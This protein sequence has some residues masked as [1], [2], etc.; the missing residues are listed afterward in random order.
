MTHSALELAYVCAFAQVR[1]CCG[2]K[3]KQVYETNKLTAILQTP[4]FRF[5]I[6]LVLCHYGAHD[7][8]CVFKQIAKRLVGDA[9]NTTSRSVVQ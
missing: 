7:L 2:N 3:D 6:I 4:L 9:Q 8:A 1:V 5:L